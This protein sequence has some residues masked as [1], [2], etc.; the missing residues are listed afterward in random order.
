[1]S[2]MIKLN[3]VGHIVNLNPFDRLIIVIRLSEFFDQWF[4][5]CYERMAVHASGSGRDCGVC[6]GFDS[7]MTVFTI[8]LIISGMYLVIKGYR[9]IGRIPNILGGR[10][11]Q[12]RNG[13]DCDERYRKFQCSVI[14][15]YEVPTIWYW[16]QDFW[17]CEKLQVNEKERLFLFHLFFK[18]YLRININ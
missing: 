4:R 15:S 17:L 14:H 5:G 13:R 8:Y 6:R 9:L 10:E 7:G 2:R 1:M 18:T 11:N 12:I 3:V 16:K